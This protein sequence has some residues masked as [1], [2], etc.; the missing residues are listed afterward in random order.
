[1]KK[2]F[3][4]LF[5]T[6][7]SVILFAQDYG[8]YSMR[9]TTSESDL[10]QYVGQRVKIMSYKGIRYSIYASEG[11]DEYIFKS[12]FKGAIGNVYTIQKIKAG[13][14]IV[15][16]L[17]D[18]SGNKIKAKVNVN[19]DHN[20]K[21]M[22]SCKSF[23]L[24]DQF[25]A[26][27]HNLTGKDINNSDG[28]PVAKIVDMKMVEVE[29]SYPQPR[30]VIKNNETGRETTWRNE[31]EAK[32]KY[33]RIGETYK[34]N[35]GMSVARIVDVND[36]SQPLFVKCEGNGYIIQCTHQQAV[37]FSKYLG[38]TLSHPKV[39][40]QYKVI[41][42]S[43]KTGT[44]YDNKF[45]FYVLQDIASSIT[46]S[47]SIDHPEINA[48]NEDL[49]GEYVSVLTKVEKPSNPTIRYGKTKTVEDK[50]VSKYSYVD[51]VI[52][53]LIFGGSRQFDFILKNV[54]SNSIKV[55]WNE[56]VF[57]DFDGTTS[58]IMHAGTKYSQR[59]GSQPATT[60]ISGAKIEDLAAPNCNVRYSDAMKEWVTDPMYPKAPALSP[61]QLRL[62]LPIQIKDV[63]NEYV[64]I[65]DVKYV[66]KHPERLNL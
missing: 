47:C 17:I 35:N 42:V 32:K 2:L 25:E 61:G 28:Q 52:D 27:K 5:M 36:S 55:V 65:F 56:A 59:E 41:G 43:N 16:D 51:N 22:Q 66:Y 11:H 44:K 30:I 3:L 8:K 33:S 60:I 10:Q 50:N 21:G 62:M 6:T 58:K 19:G 64:F 39:K 46:Y 23:F 57:V 9:H 13:K 14:Q 48:F 63:I 34:N 54:S 45:T 31:E 7:I 29:K 26:D 12:E 20:Y 1:M 37:S 18:S 4:L 24:V 40:R 49:E 38:T 53:I 15:L